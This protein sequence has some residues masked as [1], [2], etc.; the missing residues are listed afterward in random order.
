[1]KDR[2]SATWRAM[3][4]VLRSRIALWPLLLLLAGCQ[5]PRPA[6]RL[7]TLPPREAVELVN[8]NAAKITTTLRAT[9]SADGH[10]TD[11]KGRRHSF[12]L[13]AVLLYLA[14]SYMRF[15]LKSFGERKLLLGSNVERFWFFNAEDDSYFCGTHGVDEEMP[16]EVPVR[17]DQLIEA[18][19]LG[20]VPEQPRPEYGARVHRV[21]EEFQQFL[22]IVPDRSRDMYLAKEYWLDRAPPRLI[23]CVLFRDPH[24]V[25]QMESWLDDY[26]A[27][28]VGGAL[29]PHTLVAEWPEN[30]AQLRFRVSKWS[31]IEQVDPTGPQ[32]RTPP[33]CYPDDRLV[34]G[35]NR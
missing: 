1:M 28:A 20:G 9:G 7:P 5:T 23:R 22:F 24:G 11:P 13:D 27:V 6:V 2:R 21:A 16:P 18:F 12:H 29:L 4:R 33:E 25:V 14:P 19:G 3:G 32:F 31:P 17:A 10:I 34:P 8:A 30:G 26:R 15:D 35:G